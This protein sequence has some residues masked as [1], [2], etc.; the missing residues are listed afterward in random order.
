MRDRAC[1][2]AASSWF[3]SKRSGVPGCNA[4]A[5]HKVSGRGACVWFKITVARWAAHRCAAGAAT[6]LQDGAPEHGS[7]RSGPRRACLPRLLRRRCAAGPARLRCRA[8]Q[9]W[10]SLAHHGRLYGAGAAPLARSAPAQEG[11]A[12]SDAIPVLDVAPGDP[13]AFLRDNRQ[14]LGPHARNVFAVAAPVRSGTATQVALCCSVPFVGCKRGRC[15]PPRE[16]PRPRAGRAHRACLLSGILGP[17]RVGQRRA[18]GR[19][20]R[21]APGAG[22]RARW[23]A[24]W[25]CGCGP[26]APRPRRWSSGAGASLEALTLP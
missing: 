8:S 3:S 7:R 19:R 17:E 9:L 4:A 14:Q 6:Q 26:R 18:S 11:A 24:A 12:E 15:R 22:P 25:R 20:T 10:G 13:R 1:A 2:P 21:Q 5:K 23:G 16:P